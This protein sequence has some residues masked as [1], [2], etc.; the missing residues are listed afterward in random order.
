[1][2]A[3]CASFGKGELPMYKN[4]SGAGFGISRESRLNTRRQMEWA[5][6]R[7]GACI[8]RRRSSMVLNPLPRR[9]GR[10]ALRQARLS[11][12]VKYCIAISL[13]SASDSRDIL[14]SS[15]YPPLRWLSLECHP[16]LTGST[17]L[18]PVVYRC[19]VGRIHLASSLSIARRRRQGMILDQD[20]VQGTRV[21]C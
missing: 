15:T 5:R 3:G 19:F 16:E 18:T 9:L 20:I 4:N 2:R 8:D 11:S 10:R 14:L 12:L 21:D 13:A 17:R 1:M 6:R 7:A